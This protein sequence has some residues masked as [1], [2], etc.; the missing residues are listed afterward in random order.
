MNNVVIDVAY[1]IYYSMLFI[2]ITQA[3][4][5]VVYSHWIWTPAMECLQYAKF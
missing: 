2:A 3:A 1:W 5:Q 4:I